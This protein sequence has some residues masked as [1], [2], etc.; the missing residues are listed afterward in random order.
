MRT[1]PTE[2]A[3]TNRRKGFLGEQFDDIEIW[4]QDGWPTT[5]LQSGLKPGDKPCDC[6]GTPSDGGHLQRLDE[7]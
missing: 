3:G 6:R 5:A 7:R 1:T 4:L 2:R